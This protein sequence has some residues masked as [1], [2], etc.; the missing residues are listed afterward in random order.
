MEYPKKLT[1]EEK[2]DLSIHIKWKGPTLKFNVNFKEC[3]K[4]L[5]DIIYDMNEMQ[6]RRF[7]SAPLGI[8][9]VLVILIFLIELKVHFIKVHGT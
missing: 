3:F 9:S 8:S 4:L 2:A 6:D 7:V 5:V 1:S